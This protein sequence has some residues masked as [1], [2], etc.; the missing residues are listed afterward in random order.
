MSVDNRNFIIEDLPDDPE[1]S[2]FPTE[3]DDDEEDKIIRDIE[4]DNDEEYYQ[5]PQPASFVRTAPWERPS[6]YQPMNPWG[7]HSWGQNQETQSNKNPS[8]NQTGAARIDRRKKIIFV[9]LIDILIESES[10]VRETGNSKNFS[11]NNNYRKTGIMPRGLY[12][13]RLKLEVFS[14]IYAFSPD[15]VFCITNQE[16]ME[17]SKLESWN[18][19][20]KFV[21]HALSDYLRLP[22][23]NC[24]CL[25]KLGFSKSDPDVKP[26]SGLI[27]R[28][29][30]LLPKDYRYKRSDLVIIGANSGYA[31]QSNVDREMARRI[32]VDYIDIQDLLTAYS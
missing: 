16:K 25:T 9:D 12:D 3:E 15:Y 24:K 28:A 27:K 26:N 11:P 14:K 21:M 30:A 5:R 29:L 10:A 19:M 7:N 13:V 8:Y 17:K 20:T 18:I 2:L 4:E 31:N 22:G 6:T 32:K 1:D 23:N